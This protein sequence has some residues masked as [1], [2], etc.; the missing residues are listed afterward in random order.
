MIMRRLIIIIALLIP[1]AL[2]A[3]GDATIV[4]AI[5]KHNAALYYPASVERFYKENG[6]KLAW[7]APDTVKTHAWDAMMLL[8]CVRQ[9]GLVHDDYHP[10]ELLYD[11]LHTLIEKPGTDAEKAY[12]DILLTDAMIRF[13]NNLHYGKLNPVYTIKKV[14]HGTAFKAERQLSLA[15]AGNNFSETINSAQPKTKLYFDMQ[16]HTRLLVGLRSGDCY[17]IPKGQERKMAVNLE[18]MRW[19]STNGGRIHL[20]CIVRNGM[21]IYFKDN[22]NNDKILGDALYNKMPLQKS[23]LGL[24]EI[25]PSKLQ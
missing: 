1:V 19:M 13:L 20:T 17:V 8:D 18:R 14:D 11:R 15:L 23:S 5:K 16:Y 9:Y 12:F 24:D 22:G 21:V 25:H 3:E 6:Y 4:A 7:I 2:K 10:R